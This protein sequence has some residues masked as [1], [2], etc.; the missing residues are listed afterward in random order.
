MSD[1]T[2][3]ALA[4]AKRERDEA[5]ELL[6]R[7]LDQVRSLMAEKPGPT[8]WAY[9]QACRALDS[10]RARARAAEA[11][12]E[13]ARR[14]GLNGSDAYSA[15]AAVTRDDLDRVLGPGGES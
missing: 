11:L 5:R 4:D 7:A 13:Q 2:V 15:T 8:A 9:E 14:F 3:D 12:L 6:A 10:W 1:R